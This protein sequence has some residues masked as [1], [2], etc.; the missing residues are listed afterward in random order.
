RA[1]KALAL[2]Q[3]SGGNEVSTYEDVLESER[4]W[5]DLA[6]G[7]LFADAVLRNFMVPCPRLL[8]TSDALEDGQALLAATKLSALPVVD[9]EGKLAG[10]FSA[11]RMPPGLSKLERVSVA[12]AMDK[13]AVSFDEATA[14]PVLLDYF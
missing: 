12:Q 13:Q 8:R 5:A 10:L 11:D 1:E 6:G 2:A 3:Q 4:R 9:E 14:L 7:R